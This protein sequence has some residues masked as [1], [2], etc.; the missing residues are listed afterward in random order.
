MRFFIVAVA[1]L[2]SVPC[3]AQEV[4]PRLCSA[5]LASAESDASNLLRSMHLVGAQRDVAQ[6]D[7]AALKRENA[8]LKKQVDNLK[9]PAEETKP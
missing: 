2:L 7:I 5:Q 6:V 3:M 9:K 1:F 4:D 8:E